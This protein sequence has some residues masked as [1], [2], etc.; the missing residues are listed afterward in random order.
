MERAVL[1][2]GFIKHWEYVKHPVDCFTPQSPKAVEE[3][4]A[5]T[6]LVSSCTSHGQVD[7][8]KDVFWKE[9][10]EE[11]FSKPTGWDS[12]SGWEVRMERSTFS[13]RDPILSQ[14]VPIC[15]SS[16]RAWFALILEPLFF[17]HFI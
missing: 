10:G 7:V 15:C 8:R 14:H 3:V 12:G 6:K 1:P 4:H 13:T 11:A 2:A 16:V 17:F 5:I 9:K